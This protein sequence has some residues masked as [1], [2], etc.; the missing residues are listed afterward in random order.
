VKHDPVVLTVVDATPGS[1]HALITSG[2]VTIRLDLYNG[3][4]PNF[5]KLSADYEKPSAAAG[6]DAGI[7]FNSAFLAK[8]ATLPQSRPMGVRFLNPL[9]PM[10]V[11]VEGIATYRGMLMPV[12]NG[13]GMTVSH[14]PWT[15]AKSKR[16]AA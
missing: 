1:G 12:R 2:V 14:E 7:W 13:E 10:Y 9:R 3:E 6:I 11:E 15:T 5:D 16:A 4:F 8:W